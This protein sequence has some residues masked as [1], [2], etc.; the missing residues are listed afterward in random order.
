[1]REVGFGY[2]FIERDEVPL[3]VIWEDGDLYFWATDWM[4]G[5]V[6]EEHELSPQFV[7]KNFKYLGK[8]ETDKPTPEEVRDNEP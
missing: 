4:V 3:M 6:E 5:D 2:V 7:K 8:F 1:M